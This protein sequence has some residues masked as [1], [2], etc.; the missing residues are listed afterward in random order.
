M[1]TEGTALMDLNAHIDHCDDGGERGPGGLARFQDMCPVGQ[2][3]VHRYL[4]AETD[5]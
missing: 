1:V 3:L 2:G 4:H 5:A